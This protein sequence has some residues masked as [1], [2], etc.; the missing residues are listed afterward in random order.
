M[1]SRYSNAA[2][3]DARAV[4]SSAVEL[5]ARPPG[6]IGGSSGLGELGGGGRGGG[7]AG[8]ASGLS[9]AWQQPLQSQPIESNTSQAKDKLRLPQLC[10]RPHG[11]AHGSFP[12]PAA[13]GTSTQASSTSSRLALA[14]RGCGHEEPRSAG[15]HRDKE[16]IGTR[17]QRSANA[18]SAREAQT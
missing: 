7:S 14:L 13:T 8:G 9:E 1:G 11:R 17:S 12:W 2:L 4:R 18:V 5:T 16:P 15:T 3:P 10:S 6:V